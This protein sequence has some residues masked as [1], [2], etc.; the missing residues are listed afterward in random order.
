MDDAWEMGD[1]REETADGELEMLAP[2]RHLWLF[3]L[4]WMFGSA[5]DVG[6]NVEVGDVGCAQPTW[7]CCELWTLESK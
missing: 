5:V 2:Q 6:V 1:G 7:I 4:G 3:G